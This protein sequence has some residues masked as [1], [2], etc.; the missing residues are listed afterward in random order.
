MNWEN[1]RFLV[2][3]VAELDNIENCNTYC[4]KKEVWEFP[5]VFL[6]DLMETMQVFSS[7]WKWN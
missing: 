2:A 4:I 6:L 7:M 1:K 3:P 5:S